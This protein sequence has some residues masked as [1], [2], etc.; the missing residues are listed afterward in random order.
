MA[1]LPTCSKKVSRARSLA[2]RLLIYATGAA[3]HT[4]D[5]PEIEAIVRTIRDKNY[6]VRTL[7]HEIV[8]S[9]LFL[10]K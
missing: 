2:G 1:V 5:Q 3:P 10:H 6:G 9:R 7:V 8:Q 4:A